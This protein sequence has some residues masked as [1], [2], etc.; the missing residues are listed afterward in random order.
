MIPNSPGTY[1]LVLRLEYPESIEIGRLGIFE[2]PAGWYVY[3]GSAH[4]SGGL[5]ARI[6]RHLRDSKV[7]HWHIDHLRPQ[8]RATE[9]WYTLGLQK[10]ECEW[11]TA[12]TQSPGSRIPASRF[13]ASDCACPAHLVYSSRQFEPNVLTDTFSALDIRRVLLAHSTK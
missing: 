12:F 3:V 13:G 10:W 6:G 1:T 2:F 11:A 4:G 7:S 9:V 5:A 8:D